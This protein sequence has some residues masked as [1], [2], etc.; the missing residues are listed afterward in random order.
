MK[1]EALGVIPA[2]G[3]SKGVPGKN[4]RFVA[5]KPLIQWTIEAA[6]KAQS[7][8]S[9]V[10]STDDEEIATISRECGARVIIRPAEIAGDTSPVIEAVRHVIATLGAEGMP[11]PGAVALL[12]PTAPMR[13]PEDVDG[14]IK[15]F[16]D[17]G[18][19]PVCSVVRCEDNHPARMYFR[20]EDGSLEPLFPAMAE[21]R[22]QDLPPVFH[23]NGAVYVF[24]EAE[25]ESGIII[26]PKMMAFEMPADRSLN[27]DTEL[28]MSIV[29]AVMANL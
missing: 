29:N 24:G 20:V 18:L 22:R 6:L 17:R 11:I 12:Q 3:G 25:I 26:S 19:V 23:R 16:F 5:G 28:D 15:L 1:H 8:D 7:I 9:V 27:I 4:K 10:V 2:R 14:A 13:L 21:A